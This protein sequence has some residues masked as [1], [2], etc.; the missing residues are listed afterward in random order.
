[1]SATATIVERG[2]GRLRWLAAEPLLRA[3][4]HHGFTLRGGGASRG[5]F[6][7]LDFSSREGDPPERVRENWRRLEA[8]AGFPPRGWGLIS[9]V[10]GARVERVTTG[11]ASCHHR[12]GRPE[13]DAMTTDGAG[14]SLGVLT[15]DCLPVVLAVPGSRAV[16]I[17]HAG[18]R[19]TLEGVTPAAVRELCALAGAAPADV[20]A[21]LGPAIGPC[22]YRVGEEVREAFAGRWGAAHARRIFVRGGG[23]WLDLQAANLRQLRDAGVPARA[24]TAVPLCTSCRADLFFSYRRDGRTGRMLNFVVAGAGRR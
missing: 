19:G 11:R 1:M 14:I 15:A 17:A 8:A 5:R 22:C 24:V 3:G 20:I 10:H 2:R 7:S 6:A 12:R 18:W 13:A 16:A 23:W 9:Q 21:A 4:V